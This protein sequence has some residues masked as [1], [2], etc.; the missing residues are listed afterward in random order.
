M[1]VKKKYASGTHRA[2]GKGLDALISTEVVRTEGST[3][4]NEIPLDQIEPN[5]NQPRR[6]FAE[7]TLAELAESIREIGIIQP[8][9]IHQTSPDRYVIIAGERRWRAAGMAGLQTI[10]AYIRT[11]SDA[12]MMEMALIENIQREDLNVIEVALAYQQ[13]MEQ[14]G[15]TQ[16]KVSQRVGKSRT[17]ITNTLRL[18]RLPAEVQMALQKGEIDMGHARALLAIE[19]PTKQVSVFRET[20][21]KGYSVRQ[22]EDIAQRLKRGDKDSQ[23]KKTAPT[24]SLPKKFADAKRKLHSSLGVKVQ[25]VR[26][27]T[28]KGHIAIA[29]DSDETFD[30]IMERLSKIKR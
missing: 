16:E 11:L 13:L 7:N 25:I 19:S 1:A 3:T 22:V 20:I 29:F 6:E 21:R 26:T 5:H 18:L 8:I 10:P 27:K 17:V 9:T 12:S 15:M 14:D 24:R 30:K 23:G 4:I 2:L 28:G